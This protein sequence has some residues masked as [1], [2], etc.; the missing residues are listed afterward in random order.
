[1]GYLS[2]LP[3][4]VFSVSRLNHKWL[5]RRWPAVI[6]PIASQC[7]RLWPRLLSPANRLTCSWLFSKTFS[8]FCWVK[9]GSE[10]LGKRKGLKKESCSVHEALEQYTSKTRAC[11]DSGSS[12]NHMQVTGWTN[13]KP[14]IC[15]FCNLSIS[16]LFVIAWQTE[17]NNKKKRK[18]PTQ[19]SRS[20]N[21][22]LFGMYV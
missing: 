10:I 4:C 20:E 16:L 8:H 15:S 14:G 5:L 9:M 11:T 12:T 13:Q 6:P 3:T 17:P 21:I 1:M 18:N 2:L 22:L 19:I 7:N